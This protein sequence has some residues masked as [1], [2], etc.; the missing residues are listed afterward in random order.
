MFGSSYRIATVWGIPIKIHM[1]LILL[2]AF[3]ALSMAATGGFGGIVLLLVLEVGIF[4]SIALHELGHAFVALRKGCRV[5]EITLMF[6]GGVAQME[7]IPSRPADELLMAAAGPAVSIVLGVLLWLAGGRLPL[8]QELWP[9]PLLRSVPIRCNIVQ[10]VGVINLWLAA[11]NL[12]PSFPMDGGRILRASLAPRMGRLRATFVAARL[13]RI[14]AVLMGIYGLF[15]RPTRWIL[16][17]IAFFVYIAA[18]NEYQAVRLQ[19]ARRRRGPQ[20]GPFG[21]GPEGGEQGEDEDDVVIGPP[22]YG[23]NDKYHTPVRH[24][25]GDP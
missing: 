18:G 5:R 8:A 3:F 11:L 22:P 4:T 14:I 15:A 23:G 7:R 17:A 2:L 9:L 21:M 19:E 13:G 12:L 25:R 6:I 20:S 10:Y 16:V 1:S 24:T